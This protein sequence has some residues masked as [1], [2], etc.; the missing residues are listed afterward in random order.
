M[1]DPTRLTEWLA[2]LVQTPSVHPD[3][4]GPRAGTTGEARLATQLEHWF[5]ELGG[6]VHR[7]LVYPQ[8]WNV[9][10]IWRGTTD[11]WAALDVHID[12]VGVE[13]M[14]GDPFDGRVEDGKVWGRGAVDTKAS[15]G[16][17][18]TV[19]EEMRAAG[20]RPTPN[21][22]IAATVDEEV[23]QGGAKALAQWVRRQRL[24]LDTLIV[25]EPTLC[26]PVH[27]H[28]G[29]ARVEMTV[30]GK[31]AHSSQPHLG[32]NAITGAA[33]LILAL[34][35][36]SRRLRTLD[37]SPIGNPT[38][39]VTI[40]HGGHALNVIPDTCTL[41]MDRRV[42]VGERAAE[43][44]AALGEFAAAHS[45]MPVTTT[46]VRH[47]D[48]FYQPPD[49]PWLQQLAAWSGNAPAVVPYGTNACA[50]GGLARETVIFGPGS[51]DQA[52]GEVEWVAIDELVKAAEVYRKWWG[53]MV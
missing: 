21:L 2:R 28:K 10:G 1:S 17:A 40:I 14:T 32:Q 33:H 39:S 43:V 3:H 6:E 30:H 9:Y 31:A 34:D 47:F 46:V 19:L 48:A 25:A 22:L 52:H 23:G 53:L 45:V 26:Q 12:T 50:Y 15:L 16:V 20:Q 38:L 36:E 35:E 44:G 41:A 42:V 24:A 11:A 49:T 37:P 4:A 8:R 7:D 18:L 5:A 51:I 27:G 29:G 13:Q